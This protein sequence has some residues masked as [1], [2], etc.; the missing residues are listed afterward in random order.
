VEYGIVLVL[1]LVQLV[2]LVSGLFASSPTCDEPNHL[3]AG[4]AALNTGDFRFSRDHPP[5]Q[6]LICALPAELL[7]NPTLDFANRAW[8][9]AI[10]LGLF[11]KKMLLAN[12]DHF[13]NLF[14]AGRFGTVLLT[15]TL[16]VAVFLVARSLFGFLPAAAAL[17]FFAVEP[18]VLTHGRL[19]TTDLSA[20]LF[21]FLATW[22][23]CRFLERNDKRSALLLG[24]ALGAGLLSKHSVFVAVPAFALTWVLYHR[25]TLWKRFISKKAE[26]DSG[27]SIQGKRTIA[28]LLIVCV[29]SFFVIWAGF[30]FEIG[31]PVPEERPPHWSPTWRFLQGILFPIEYSIGITDGVFSNA[32]DPTDPAW[33]MMRNWLP[34]FDYFDGF[35]FQ[36]SHARGFHTGYLLGQTSTVGW[37][38]YYPVNFLIKTPLVLLAATLVGFAAW[39]RVKDLRRSARLC[40]VVPPLFYFVSICL[41]NHANIGWRHAL[42]VIPFFCLWAGAL[43][44]AVAFADRSSVSRSNAIQIPILVT[45]VLVSVVSVAP[46]CPD[47]LPFLNLAAR[48]LAEPTYW[49]AD[50]NLDWGQDV[51]H[52][53]RFADENDID[54]LYVLHFGAPELL[55]LYGIPA[56]TP[57]RDEMDKQAVYAIS[58]SVMCGLGRFEIVDRFRKREP[59]YT[60]GES[61]YIYDLRSGPEGSEG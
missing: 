19:V 37:W 57:G 48:N 16:S 44:R 14:L 3:A 40:Y 53:K 7:Y 5:L 8:E 1:L 41:L 49:V 35:F 4:L 9:R 45:V 13:E 12:P 23:F 20:A 38:Y 15:L 24:L 34:A 18:N 59:D 33:V 55:K 52:L 25:S 50:S 56:K 36:L 46:Y 10:H 27:T 30:G 26:G 42:P 54:E 31:D 17:A 11:S 2:F 39:W 61:I 28:N 29:V 60:V 21:F 6:N 47:T 43:I 51:R 22:A 32:T 58:A